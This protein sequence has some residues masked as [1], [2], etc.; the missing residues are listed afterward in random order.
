M[1]LS[2]SRSTF[3]LSIYV[4]NMYT[5]IVCMP[6]C[7]FDKFA[8]QLIQRTSFAAWNIICVSQH[9][10]LSMPSHVTTY[11]TIHFVA[12]RFVFISIC[13]QPVSKHIAQC[14]VPHLL[15]NNQ[16]VCC[17]YMYLKYAYI[18]ISML[19]IYN[20]VCLYKQWKYSCSNRRLTTHFP[21]DGSLNGAGIIGLFADT[22]IN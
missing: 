16:N 9:K 3:V 22:R 11:L 6:K 1:S 2:L 7:I 13:W 10:C 21:L 4:P 15:S 18:Y 20:I 19:S 12:H 5:Y 8:C 14:I 17:I